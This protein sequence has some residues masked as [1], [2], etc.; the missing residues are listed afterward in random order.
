MMERTSL[1]TVLLVDD[2]AFDQRLYRRVM[3]R[4][5]LVRLVVSFQMADAA[6]VWLRAEGPGTVDV[7]FLD[8]NMPRMNGFEFLSAA[9]E[10]FGAAS[11]PPVVM[12]LTTSLDPR[13]RAQAMTFEAVKAYI[14]KPLTVGHLGEAL[15]LVNARVAA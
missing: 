14:S 15:S 5:G 6:L 11:L 2:D 3:E 4:S 13:D 9:G 8:I 10:L 12:M 7:I 1:G